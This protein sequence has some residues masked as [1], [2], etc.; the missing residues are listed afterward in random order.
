MAQGFLDHPRNG[1]RRAGDAARDL[2][3]SL[4][5]ST[6][7]SSSSTPSRVTCCPSTRAAYRDTYS[8]HAIKHDV[9]RTST[10][11]RPAPDQRDA[12][13]APERAVR[14]HQRGGPPLKVATFNGGLF[15]PERHPFLERYAVGDAHLQQA[16]DKLARVD[17]QFVDYRDLAERHLG[18]IYEGLLEYH[19]EAIG[20]PEDGWTVDLLNDRGERKAPAA[21]T[22]RTSS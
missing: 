18:T 13:A 12:L 8:L 3:N 21:T 2:D 6:G 4:I 17:G 20:K 14:H 1:L 19:L 5:C 11:A 16:I 10:G 22:P 7:C 15:D 9:A